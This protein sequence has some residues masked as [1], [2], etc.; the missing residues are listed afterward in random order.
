MRRPRRYKS[1]DDPNDRLRVVRALPNTP[2]SIPPLLQAVGDSSPEIAKAALAKL[3]GLARSPEAS[4]LR[5]RMVAADPS[6]VRDWAATM[7]EIGDLR[8]SVGTAIRGLGADASGTRLAAAIALGE[9][10]DPRATSALLIAL[11]DPIA[12]VR[13]CGLLARAALGPQPEC[14]QR[15][16]AMLFDSDDGVRT[17]AVDALVALS[18]DPD[19]CVQAALDDPSP[20]VRRRLAEYAAL[21]RPATAGRLLAD[22]QADVRAAAAWSLAHHQSPDLTDHLIDWLSDTAWEVR[23][24]ACRAV[25]ATGDETAICALTPMLGD[26]NATVRAAALNVLAEL[27]GHELGRVSAGALSNAEPDL[28]RFLVYALIRCP[29]TISVPILA[30]HTADSEADVRLA[31]VHIAGALDDPRCAPMLAPLAA[32]ADPAVR[33]AAATQIRSHSTPL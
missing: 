26:P 32:D 25:G 20:R 31:V 4:Y 9:L 8:L 5:E 1:L 21:L 15:C 3:S 10:G 17:A 30:V 27:P 13:R 18:I 14:E 11:R 2:A 29:A 22:P 6:V 16:R 23:R 7:R 12:G 24:A 19:R 33:H 28:R